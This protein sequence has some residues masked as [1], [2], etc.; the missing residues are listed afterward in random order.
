MF[1]VCCP[2]L[3]VLSH[4]CVYK[5][6]RKAEEGM[7]LQKHNYLPS[8][9]GLSHDTC[10][11]F[12]EFHP[13]RTLP[14]PIIYLLKCHL[15]KASSDLSQRVL[16]TLFYDS[17]EPCSYILIPFIIYHGSTHLFPMIKSIMKSEKVGTVIF[18]T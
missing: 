7:N 2:R 12:P 13:G 11:T 9:S 16:G 14:V 10:P 4:H 1:A 3:L 15:G 8:F 5:A 6:D 17:L 18:L